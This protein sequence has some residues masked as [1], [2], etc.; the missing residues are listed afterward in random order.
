VEVLV[1]VGVIAVLLAL[2]LPAIQLVRE[3]ASGLKCQNHLHQLLTAYHNRRYNDRT[4]FVP[5]N[6][7]QVHGPYLDDAG[8]GTGSSMD[9]VTAKVFHCPNERETNTFVTANQVAP[10]YLAVYNAGVPT[11]YSEYGGTNLIPFIPDNIRCRVATSVPLPTPNSWALEI[12]DATDWDFDDIRVI[13]TPQ[14]NCGVDV[15]AYSKSASY[16]FQ[17]VASDKIT[18]L[19]NPFQP[20]SSSQSQAYLN[21]AAPSSYGINPKHDKFMSNDG[22]KVLFVEY[23]KNV[24]DV[25]GTAPPDNWGDWYA[26]RHAQSKRLNVAFYGGHVESYFPVHIDPRITELQLQFWTPNTEQ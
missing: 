5:I 26:A 17:L 3:S 20:G 12:E 10:A 19:N 2:L 13:F 8:I 14:S 7:V 6:W 22:Y 1:I 23:Y 4:P 15:N 25:V 24:A 21:I 11:S 9:F 16:T 18:I